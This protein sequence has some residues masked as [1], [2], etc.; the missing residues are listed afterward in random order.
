MDCDPETAKP[1]TPEEVIAAN[2]VIIPT[3]V[4]ESFNHLITKFWNNDRQQAVFTEEQAIEEIIKRMNTSH[5]HIYTNKWLDVNKLYCD[6]WD[7]SLNSA[8]GADQ[9]PTFI[10]RS[11]TWFTYI[12]SLQIP[13]L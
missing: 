1:I 8:Y 5:Y 12:D 10:F 11:I 7:V 3:E 6:N 4:I 13:Y 9:V 2:N